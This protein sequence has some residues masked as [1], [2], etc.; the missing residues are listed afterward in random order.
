MLSLFLNLFF[1]H[2]LQEDSRQTGVR[3]IIFILVFIIIPNMTI[4]GKYNDPME[5][6]TTIIVFSV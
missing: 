1:L 3:S 4:G 5:G 6:K 2:T